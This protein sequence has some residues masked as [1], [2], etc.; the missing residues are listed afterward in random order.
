MEILEM[1]NSINQIKIHWKT[2]PTV[3]AE[4]SI[5]EIK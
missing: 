5:L 4:K 3:T 2:S 1:K